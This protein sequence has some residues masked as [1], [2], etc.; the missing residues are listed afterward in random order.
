MGGD[1]AAIRFH[2]AW[3]S[4]GTIAHHTITTNI[5]SPEDGGGSGSVVQHD[6]I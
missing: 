3:W 6:D 1:I 5:G 4:G 2:L